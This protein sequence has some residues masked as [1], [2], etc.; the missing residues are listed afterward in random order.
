MF[1]NKLQCVTGM[2]VTAVTIVCIVCVL[3]SVSDISYTLPWTFQHRHY[4][5]GD[6]L[7]DTTIC[8]W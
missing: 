8:F 3:A 5:P 4:R 6:Q 7:W 1:A 2:C